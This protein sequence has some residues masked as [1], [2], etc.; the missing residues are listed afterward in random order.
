[1]AQSIGKTFYSNVLK[2]PLL[3]RSMVK[4]VQRRCRSNKNHPD[5]YRRC[6][7]IMHMN[8]KHIQ[9]LRNKQYCFDRLYNI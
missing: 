7:I 6:K 5:M 2:Y 3:V 8:C 9:N 1:M 4:D